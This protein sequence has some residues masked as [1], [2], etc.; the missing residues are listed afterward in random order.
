[1][2]LQTFYL[3]IWYVELHEKTHQVQKKKSSFP[4]EIKEELD[5]KFYVIHIDCHE[6]EFQPCVNC[7]TRKIRPLPQDV[8]ETRCP[9][10]GKII[11]IKRDTKISKHN[12]LHAE[13]KNTDRIK[14]LS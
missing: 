14:Q 2:I 9:S 10:I 4:V 6:H 12:M 8:Y 5:G 11:R 13:K 1:M 7:V 3:I